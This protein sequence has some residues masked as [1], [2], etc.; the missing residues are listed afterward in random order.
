MTEFTLHW[1]TAENGSEPPEEV[2]EL[3]ESRLGR[4]LLLSS[5]VVKEFWNIVLTASAITLGAVVSFTY[6]PSLMESG[7]SFWVLLIVAGGV[8]TL[9]TAAQKLGISPI[10]FAERY[11]IYYTLMTMAYV[12]VFV[13][14]RRAD[15]KGQIRDVTRITVDSIPG[16]KLIPGV[17]EYDDDDDFREAL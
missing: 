9:D 10:T 6:Y 7:W 2:E 3:R 4:A 8:V 15:N 14:N 1:P 11:A 13:A 17:T 12:F 16:Q 5:V